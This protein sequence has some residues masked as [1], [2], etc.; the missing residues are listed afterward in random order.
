MLVTGLSFII[1]C[2]V[3]FDG[4]LGGVMGIV[5]MMY[6]EFCQ[7]LWILYDVVFLVWQ[8]V[9]VTHILFFQDNNALL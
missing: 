7:V 6:F 5:C 9:V 4:V 1:C 3:A 2:S 8:L